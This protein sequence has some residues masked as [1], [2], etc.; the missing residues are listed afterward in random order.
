MPTVTTDERTALALLTA[1]ADRAEMHGAEH[2][3]DL[4]REAF[5]LAETAIV[6]DL[7]SDPDVTFATVTLDHIAARI[8]ATS[9]FLAGA[10]R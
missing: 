2:T 4:L 6:G 9:R 8:T 7:D 3:A 5:N 1:L 10:D